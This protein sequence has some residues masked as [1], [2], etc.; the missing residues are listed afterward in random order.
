[1]IYVNKFDFRVINTRGS[2][3]REVGIR[4]SSMKS[5]SGLSAFQD[6]CLSYQTFYLLIF[7][8]HCSFTSITSVTL[9]PS[10][11]LKSLANPVKGE[12]NCLSLK[13]MLLQI[14]HSLLR[15]YSSGF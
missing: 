8:M 4:K 13:L 9:S 3:H 1:M 6:D 5:L 14:S 12:E 10:L 2:E 11:A 7:N 15:F